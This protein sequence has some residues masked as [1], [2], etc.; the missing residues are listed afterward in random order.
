MGVR[1]WMGEKGRGG[2]CR[3]ALYWG[4]EVVGGV[5]KRVLELRTYF[6]ALQFMRWG[7][8]LEYRGQGRFLIDERAG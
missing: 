1:V 5:G 2:V 7:Q 8:W 4:V 6:F 3:L